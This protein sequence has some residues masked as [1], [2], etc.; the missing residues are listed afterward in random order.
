MVR[1]NTRKAVA[2]T[3]A[4]LIALSGFGGTATMGVMPDK[5]ILTA[6]AASVRTVTAADM[7]I[8]TPYL[9]AEVL[10][11]GH[12]SM[13]PYEFE[14]SITVG[15]TWG[16]DKIVYT[17]AVPWEIFST[18]GIQLDE[19]DDVLLR[20]RYADGVVT[21]NPFTGKLVTTTRPVVTTTEK[22]YIS[23]ALFADMIPESDSGNFALQF[24]TTE[25][26]SETGDCLTGPIAR[27]LAKDILDNEYLEFDYTKGAEL[28]CM[29][30]DSGFSMFHVDVPNGK[31]T[32]IGTF[33]PKDTMR[34]LATGF[35]QFPEGVGCNTVEF[36]TGSTT[37]TFTSAEWVE[38]RYVNHTTGMTANACRIKFIFDD[39]Y[40]EYF[41]LGTDY[42]V[43]N[44]YS[45]NLP[46]LKDDAGNDVTDANGNP[47][48]DGTDSNGNPEISDETL[49]RPSQSE[50]YPVTVYAGATVAK[51]MTTAE[52][53][54]GSFVIDDYDPSV[55]YYVRVGLD[56][57]GTDAVYFR[58]DKYLKAW[59]KRVD[60][61]QT[62][63]Y[64][65]NINPA[66]FRNELADGKITYRNTAMTSFTKAAFAKNVSFQLMTR[67]CTDYEIS[68]DY[69]A[70]GGSRWTY[71]GIDPEKI[72]EWGENPGAGATDIP[73][74]GNPG[75]T[76]HV[77][78][79][80]KDGNEYDFDFELPDSGNGSVALPDGEYHFEDEDTELF[81]DTTV[82]SGTPQDGV[83]VKDEVTGS[84]YEVTSPDGSAYADGT[85]EDGSFDNVSDMGKTKQEVDED[86]YYHGFTYDE[87]VIN[88]T[89]PEKHKR[90]SGYFTVDEDGTLN[91]V[92]PESDLKGD[93]NLDGEFTLADVV[94]LQKYILAV[95]SFQ[96]E[97]FINADVCT[98]GQVNVFDLAIL[99]RMLLAKGAE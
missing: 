32:T 60:T 51:E 45:R 27:F 37:K 16:S 94:L 44:D 30:S 58:Y 10:Y 26:N 53:E 74:E 40:V 39:G 67:D 13:Y 59:V 5:G 70:D 83:N 34:S 21:I 38:A 49:Q 24:F 42:V 57:N 78:G 8:D 69:G 97:N 33:S 93:V 4:L 56:E 75:D 22:A 98:D 36:T 54:K 20:V 50:S 96:I 64:N 92:F 82:E 88:S 63:V 84:R 55:N 68:F 2:F 85:A 1:R 9:S 72:E 52:F 14:G 6:S 77:T 66:T 46:N 65:A 89:N 19:S 91:K 18:K 81:D 87:G 71:I 47:L 12:Y 23:T 29:K 99:K 15:Q 17:I 95:E 80:D 11:T 86:G 41:V 28:L 48:V 76:V 61:S 35:E 7:G 79:T 3:A 25:R 31:V 43:L 90:E 73:V 62:A